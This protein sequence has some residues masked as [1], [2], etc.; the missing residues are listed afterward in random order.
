MDAD[1]EWAPPSARDK[2]FIDPDRELAHRF[3]METDARSRARLLGMDWDALR[4][5]RRRLVIGAWI[6]SGGLAFAILLPTLLLQTSGASIDGVR[7]ARFY[8]LTVALGAIAAYF[9]RLIA[10]AV[11]VRIVHDPKKHG[12]YEQ[13]RLV[14]PAVQALWFALLTAVALLFSVG[15]FESLG[16]VAFAGVATMLPLR[17]ISRLPVLI[18]RNYV[19]TVPV[20]LELA[21]L[22]KEHWV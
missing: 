17:G 14:E 15:R 21:K 10:M 9:V 12:T 19:S 4:A 8:V 2:Q 3:T 1:G 7:D 13:H 16:L 22:V 5:A 11:A 18:E 6:I 20:F